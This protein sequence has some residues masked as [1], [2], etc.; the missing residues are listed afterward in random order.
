MVLPCS[1][2][3]R[4]DLRESRAGCR[5]KEFGADVSLLA[6][7]SAEST[8]HD[9]CDPCH[10]A[11]VRTLRCVVPAVLH[12]RDTAAGIAVRSILSEALAK[13][14]WRRGSQSDQRGGGRK[15]HHGPVHHNNKHHGSR[16]DNVEVVHDISRRGAGNATARMDAT[17]SDATL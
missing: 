7:I 13:R 10:V 3:R 16:I 4:G 1:V 12:S 2:H 8:K 5:A 9:G 6:I 11:L 15:L 17:S 14:C